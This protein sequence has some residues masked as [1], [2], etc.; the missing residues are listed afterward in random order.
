MKEMNGLEAIEYMKQGGLVKTV[1]G[2]DIVINKIVDNIVH[3][4]FESEK[5]N[6]SWG[7]DCSFD[8]SKSYEEYIEPKQLIGWER[9]DKGKEFYY[10]NELSMLKVESERGSL[11]NA[12][13][14]VMANYFSTEEKAEEINFKQTLFRKLQ[15]FSD[16]NGGNKIDWN[17]ADKPKYYISFNYST[18]KFYIDFL[19]KIA[20]FGSV[21]FVSEE[22]TQQ[23]IEL[24]HDDLIEYFTMYE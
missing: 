20:V 22:V 3:Y 15:R 19:Y 7:I 24:F 11:A 18:N 12:R 5:N 21:Y 10:I 4:I 1:I 23:A 9:V 8:F 13:N 2:D 6:G 16:E 17:N 14:G